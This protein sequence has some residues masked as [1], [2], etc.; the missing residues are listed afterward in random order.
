MKR[1]QR[2]KEDFVCEYCNTEVKGS[3]Y[4]NH[5]PT[6]LY[7][8][9]VDIRPGDRAAT[10]GGL[11]EPVQVEQKGEE[12][13]LTH[14]CQKCGYAKVNRSDALDNFEVLVALAKGF[15]DRNFKNSTE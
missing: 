5:C 4:T 8:K 2:R 10:C 13:Q 12:Y 3:G 6:C 15:T 14:R 9:H 11:M 1:F 7:S